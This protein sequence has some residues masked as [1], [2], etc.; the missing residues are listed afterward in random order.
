[1]L[2]HIS[3]YCCIVF[4]ISLFAC[5]D[6]DKKGQNDRLDARERDQLLA[7]KLDL[8]GL[9]VVQLNSQAKEAAGEW[10]AFLSLKSEIENLT[11]YSLQQIINNSDNLVSAAKALR[12]GIPEE[13]KAVP[14][15]S[16]INVILTQSR[17]LN[18]YAG[19]SQPNIEEIT[20]Y[21]R[22]VF[23]AFS[24]LK[25][26]LNEIFIRQSIE[27]KF[28]GNIPI[29]STQKKETSTESKRK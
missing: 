29:D 11:D 15:Q 16:R 28:D 20:R 6:S 3:F 22:R 4:I 24:D 5:K 2:K 17:M 21:G 7:Q 14:V 25:I 26:Q 10:M 9:P 13:F 12:Q 27:L 1:M 23:K 19:R 8:K 18:Q